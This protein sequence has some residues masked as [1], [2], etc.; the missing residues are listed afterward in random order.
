MEGKLSESDMHLFIQ[1]HSKEKAFQGR[2]QFKYKVED[3]IGITQ[4]KMGH[5]GHCRMGEQCVQRTKAR[6]TVQ[7]RV[8]SSC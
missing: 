1:E 3:S 6:L 4:A 5:D 7:R 2:R 8:S